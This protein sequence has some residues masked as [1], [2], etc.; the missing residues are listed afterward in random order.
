L[1]FIKDKLAKEEIERNKPKEEGG[2][3]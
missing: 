1:E 3:K 2:I